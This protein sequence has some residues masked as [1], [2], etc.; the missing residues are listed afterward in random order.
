MLSHQNDDSQITSPKDLG[1]IKQVATS[2]SRVASWPL[3][4]SKNKKYTFAV[5]WNITCFLFM[6]Y[7][8]IFQIWYV[9]NNI[10]T[11]SFV[12]IGH[13]YITLAMNTICL[14]RLTMPWM[15]EYRQVIKEFLDKIHLFHQKDNSEYANKIYKYIEKICKIFTVFV[16]FQLYGGIA[17]FNITPAYKNFKAGMYSSNKPVNATYETAVYLALPFDCFTDI[18]G[19]MFLS[20]MSLVSTSIGS[21][22]FCL[23]HLLLSLIVFHIWGNLKILKHNLDNFPKPAS[24][25]TSIGIPWYTDEE[26]KNI[27]TLI[28][29][30][31]NHHRN[32]MDFMAKTSSAYSFFLLLNF[33]FYQ[34]VGCIILL[35]CSK[36]DSEALGNYGPLTVVLFQQLI[37]I[38]VTFELL[39]SQSEKLIDAVYGLPWEC[40]DMKNRK[41]VLFFLQNVQE[42]I[43]LKACGMV[44]VG[45][46]TM[47]AI[48]KACC[49]YF[50]MLRTVTASEEMT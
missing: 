35:Q 23:W 28:V 6:S 11:T 4:E 33:A 2:L 38:S 22:S 44:P 27:S 32:I 40:M 47:A 41:L 48:L 15:A 16:H 39:G 36:L 5:K 14:Q 17:L 10:S 31:V 43:N 29:E 34:I 9:R 8:F 26:S 25:M 49:S 19:H 12:V 46:Q 13:T 21:T 7:I 24:Q 37:Q 1:Y 3:M 20:L 18:K 42:P 30:L 50:I 45:V